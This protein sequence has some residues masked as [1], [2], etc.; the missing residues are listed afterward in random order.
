LSGEFVGDFF[1]AI[2]TD[3]ARDEMG[4]GVELSAGEKRLERCVLIEVVL[5]GGLVVAREPLNY[6][7]QLRQGAPLGFNLLDIVRVDRAEHHPGDLGIV[8]RRVVHELA[9]LD[10]RFEVQTGPC[11]SMEVCDLRRAW[12]GREDSNLRLLTPEGSALSTELRPGT[13]PKATR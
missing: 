11:P 9:S 10:T 7:V 12:P 8:M 6:L 5:E 13:D 2:P 1:D 4:V 3:C